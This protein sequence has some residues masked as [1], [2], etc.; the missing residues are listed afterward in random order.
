MSVK[1]QNNKV[2]QESNVK[3]KWASIISLIII[4]FLFCD[5]LKKEIYCNLF[6]ELNV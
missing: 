4:V 2:V 1:R 3:K 6:I 5:K